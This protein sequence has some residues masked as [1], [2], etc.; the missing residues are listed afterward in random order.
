VI[1]AGSG[2]RIQGGHHELYRL[3][4]TFSRISTFDARL[5]DQPSRALWLVKWLLLIPHY[6]ILFFLWI[7]FWVVTV[8]AFLPIKD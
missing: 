2:R 7:A 3:P 4:T 8:I 1:N 6:I 5:F